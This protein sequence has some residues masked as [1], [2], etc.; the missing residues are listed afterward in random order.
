MNQFSKD[1]RHYRRTPRTMNDAWGAYAK[2]HVPSD[3]QSKIAGFL[4]AA[5]YGVAIGAFWYV[6]LLARAQ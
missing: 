4:W 3:K 6:L 5:F 2:L 1:I